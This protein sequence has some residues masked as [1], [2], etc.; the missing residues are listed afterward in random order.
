MGQRDN[1]ARTQSE[2]QAFAEVRADVQAFAQVMADAE[3]RAEA[4][5]NVEADG[6]TRIEGFFFQ[7]RDYFNSYF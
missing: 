3:A 7:V 4:D 6:E 2:A 5:A 1:P